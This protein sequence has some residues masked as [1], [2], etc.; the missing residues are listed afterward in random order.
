MNWCQCSGQRHGAAVQQVEHGH[1][2]HGAC[3]H[4]RRPEG[5]PHEYGRGEVERPE[6]RLPEAGAE[7][8]GTLHVAHRR[9]GGQRAHQEAGMHVAPSGLDEAREGREE[10]GDERGVL[11]RRRNLARVPAAVTWNGLRGRAAQCPRADERRQR[12]AQRREVRG[13]RD[14]IGDHAHRHRRLLWR[15]RCAPEPGE[16]VVVLVADHGGARTPEDPAVEEEVVAEDDHQSARDKNHVQRARAKRH[17]L[18]PPQDL[19]FNVVS[20]RRSVDFVA[21]LR[22]YL[23]PISKHIY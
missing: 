4:R 1:G 20:N 6:P 13:R 7:E 16:R 21:L 18:P 19:L 12:E 23:A 10:A 15:R 9:I 5:D 22:F 2:E 11:H 14:A 3:E 17:R 8:H